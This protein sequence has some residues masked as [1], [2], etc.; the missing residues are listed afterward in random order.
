MST[1]TE[2]TIE[3]VPRCQRMH[4]R[5]EPPYTARQCEGEA[6]DTIETDEGEALRICALCKLDAAEGQHLDFQVD[7]E[8]E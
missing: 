5:E 4:P 6:I 7:S 1:E 2:A 3:T 8:E